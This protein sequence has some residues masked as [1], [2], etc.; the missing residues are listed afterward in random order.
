MQP[1]SEGKYS[2]IVPYRIR[3]GVTGHR[4]LSDEAALRE[5]VKGIVARATSV[6]GEIFEMFDEESQ[7][8]IRRSAHTPMALGILSPLAEGADRLVAQEVLKSPDAV[9]EVALPLVGEEYIKDFQTDSSQRE[10]LDLL[11]EARHP[12]SLRTKTLEEEYPGGDLAEERR[13]AYRDVGHY[14]VDHCD[15]LIAL[16]DGQASRGKGG[17]AEIVEY[18]RNS[19]R[20]M[21]VIS[22]IAP[23][24]VIVEKGPFGLNA[25]VMEDFERFNSFYIPDDEQDRYVENMYNETFSAR[26]KEKKKRFLRILWKKTELPTPDEQE[27]YMLKLEIAN[28]LAAAIPETLSDIREKVLPYYVRASQIAKHNQ[29]KYQIAGSL[30]YIL[31]ALAVADVA[32]ATLT[33]DVRYIPTIAFSIEILL[34]LSILMLVYFSHRHRSHKKWVENRFLAERIRASIFFAV[35]GVEVSPVHIPPY[36]GVPGKPGDWMIAAFKEIWR[37]LPPMGGC[38]GK[39][40]LL[41]GYVKKFWID[42]Q[43]TYHERKLASCG[44]KSRSLEIAGFAVFF[45]AMMAPAAHLIPPFFGI[46]LGEAEKALIFIALTLPAVGAALGGIRGHREFSRLQRQSSYMKAAL[47]G[48]SASFDKVSNSRELEALLLEAEDEMMRE[49]GEWLS[50][51]RTVKLHPEV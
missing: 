21:I 46:G 34:L 31:A 27:E 35:S 20:P 23:H 45:I 43:V 36:M 1:H 48:I 49:A 8:L 19:D 4:T 28:N 37:K 51:M 7:E 50:L 33:L 9:L 6:S 17:T 41:S 2:S 5:K 13:N 47:E 10:F 32:A 15:V 38:S 39:C 44:E 29:R 3:L 18:A 24:D 12:V 40:T 14:V 42:D 22:T 11:H 26:L 25:G 16:W 30:V